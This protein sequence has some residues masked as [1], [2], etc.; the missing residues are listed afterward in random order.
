MA[1]VIAG[2]KDASSIL[3]AAMLALTMAAVLLRYRRA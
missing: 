2:A 1:Q 3:V